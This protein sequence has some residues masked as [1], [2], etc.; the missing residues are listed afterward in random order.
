MAGSVMFLLRIQGKYHLHTGDT[1][2]HPSI[3][4]NAPQ[5]FGKN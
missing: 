2:F 5:L 1:R 3:A 4:L